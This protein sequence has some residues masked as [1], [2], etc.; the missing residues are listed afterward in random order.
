MTD[1]NPT[2]PNE[3]NPNKP[4]YSTSDHATLEALIRLNALESTTSEIKKV[5]EDARLLAIRQTDR[6]ESITE[7]QTRQNGSIADMVKAFNSL[8]TTVNQKLENLKDLINTLNASHKEGIV[9]VCAEYDAKIENM[10]ISVLRQTSHDRDRLQRWIIVFMGT[11]IAGLII[12]SV[13]N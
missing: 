6:L 8:S 3:Y 5:A 4:V 12:K 11:V 10:N 9:K 1:G 7:W 2:N 13:L